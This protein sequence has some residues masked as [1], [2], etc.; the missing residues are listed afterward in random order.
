MTDNLRAILHE[1]NPLKWLQFSIFKDREWR[2]HMSV[3]VM[4]PFVAG[5]LSVFVGHYVI[6]FYIDLKIKTL[7]QYLV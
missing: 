6:D 4:F 3:I 2:F 1:I 7:T 5:R